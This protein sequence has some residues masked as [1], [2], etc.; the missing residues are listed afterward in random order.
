MKS[1]MLLVLDWYTCSIIG[2]WSP[3]R[4]PGS[5]EKCITADDWVNP[6]NCDWVMIME[7]SLGAFHA[8]STWVVRRIDNFF[9]F[10]KLLFVIAWFMQTLQ[11]PKHICH[12]ITAA[13]VNTSNK[14][15]TS[16][17]VGPPHHSNALK[18]L[19]INK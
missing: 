11:S 12:T 2:W 19:T 16:L 18:V 15:C 7:T 14:L 1:L 10:V 5:V 9:F 4:A 13:A 17:D 8:S 6:L 3:N